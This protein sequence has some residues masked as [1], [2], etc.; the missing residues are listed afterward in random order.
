M[1]NKTSSVS[2]FFR[3]ISQRKAGLHKSE[4]QIA[5]SYSTAVE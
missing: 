3:A 1:T 5:V 4:K 2:G